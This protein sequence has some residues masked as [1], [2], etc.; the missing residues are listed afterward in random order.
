MYTPK[1]SNKFKYLLIVSLICILISCIFSL[2]L[3]SN[4]VNLNDIFAGLF[5][6][7]ANTFGANIVKKEF[8]VLYLDFFVEVPWV[9]LG[10]LCSLLQ[11]TPLQI[12]LY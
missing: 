7:D 12:H 6:T 9:Y 5:K 4:H 2:L 8:H 10:H 3:G 11:E 1:K